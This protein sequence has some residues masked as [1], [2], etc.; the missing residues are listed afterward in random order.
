MPSLWALSKGI[1]PIKRGSSGFSVDYIERI[2]G[3]VRNY[4]SKRQ[5]VRRCKTKNYIGSFWDYSIL[6]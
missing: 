1:S 3:D 6:G 5:E 4:L 2:V